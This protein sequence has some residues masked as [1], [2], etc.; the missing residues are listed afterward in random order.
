MAAPALE[1]LADVSV[2]PEVAAVP[3]ADLHLH[4]E[5][6]PRLERIVARRQGRGPYDWRAWARQLAA[7]IEEAP[8]AE[9]L[10]KLVEENRVALTNLGQDRPK[11]LAELERRIEERRER[12]GR[13]AA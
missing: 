10:E 13:L 12:L 3:K 7:A 4:Q 8:D 11:W 9:W 6:F 1:P 2:S 5:V